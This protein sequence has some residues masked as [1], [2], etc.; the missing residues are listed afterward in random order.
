M[1][2]LDTRI[3][4]LS[5]L[6]RIPLIQELIRIDSGKQAL[7]RAGR[8]ARR[9]TA[10]RYRSEQARSDS[11]RLGQIIYFLRFRSPATNTSAEDLALCDML[12]DKLRAKGQW[13]GEYSV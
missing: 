6:E 4:A 1:E 5:D 10:E 9:G 12:A 8:R 11:D 2:D 3:R 7:A 13:T